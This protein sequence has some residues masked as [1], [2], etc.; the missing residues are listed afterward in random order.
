MSEV[1]SILKRVVKATHL[2]LKVAIEKLEDNASREE[3]LAYL[4][5]NNAVSF[6]IPAA[7]HTSMDNIGQFLELD[8]SAI[9]LEAF[10]EIVDDILI[11]SNIIDDS[12]HLLSSDTPEEAIE[13]T[14]D[15]FFQLCIFI[16]LQKNSYRSAQ[17]TANIVKVIMML[18]DLPV[19]HGATG[20]LGIIGSSLKFLKRLIL[21]V[22][23]N[24][25]DWSKGAREEW[26]KM[27]D[28]DWNNTW[29]TLTDDDRKKLS[30]Q[31]IKLFSDGIYFLMV[32]PLYFSEA[33]SNKVRATYGFDPPGE[34]L[35][36]IGDQISERVL[37]LSLSDKIKDT[38]DLETEITYFI[39]L[40]LRSSLDSGGVGLELALAGEGKLEY[41]IGAGYKLSVTLD[42]LPGVDA[43]LEF[44]IQKEGLGSNWNLGDSKGTRLNFGKAMFTSTASVA[45]REIDSKLS[46]QDCSF[47]LARNGSD[48]FLQSLIPEKGLQAGFE[49]GFGLNFKKGFYVDGGSGI[50]VFI[51]LHLELGPVTMDALY[52]KASGIPDGEGFQL[53]TSVGF[54]ADI[55]GITATV[56]QIGLL[57][58]F[59]TA[60]E[61]KNFHFADYSIALK[62]PTQI[63]LSIDTGGLT[64]GGFISFNPDKGEYIG[65]IELSYKKVFSIKA[66]AIITT[67]LP[68]GKPGYSLLLLISAEFEPIQLG[69]GFTWNGI[70]GILGVH[71][72]AKIDFLRAGLKTNTLKSILFPENIVANIARIV[73]DLNQAFPQ[74]QGHYLICPV[75]KFGWG[76]PTLITIE[77]GILIEIPFERLVIF[78]VIRAILPDQ[79]KPVL[80]LQVNFLGV[81]DFEN[82]LI[83]FDASLYD[84]S[85]LTLTLSGDFGLRIGWGDNPMFILSAGGFHPA[86]NKEE[87]NGELPNMQRITVSLLSGDNPRATLQCYFAI[88]SNTVQFGAKAELYASSSGFNVY[89]YLAFDV[90]IR[91]LGDFEAGFA[92]GLALRRNTTVLMGI[93]VEGVLA[94]TEPWDL[95]GKGSISFFFFSISVPF[96]ARWGGVRELV[97]VLIEDIKALLTEEIEKDTNWVSAIPVNNNLHVS[98]RK[99]ATAGPKVL[100]HPFGVL[101]FRQTLVPLEIDIDKFGNKLP[102][103]AKNF[104]IKINGTGLSTEPVKDQFA[105]GN[106]LLMEDAEKLSRPS[107]EQMTS[108]FSITGSAS[109]DAPQL[110]NKSVD[111]EFSYLGRKK[112]DLPMKNR[113]DFRKAMFKSSTRMSAVAGSPLSYLNSRVSANAPEKVTVS[114]QQYAIAGISDLK[115]YIGDEVKAGSYSEVYQQYR[116]IIRQRPELSE[117]LQ[118]VGTHEVNM[119]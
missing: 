83:S 119:N 112:K 115:L 110:I 13:E 78:G 64:G 63:G 98:V 1:K 76:T 66:I 27:S 65:A 77:V 96:H 116:N 20:T 105:P 82:K 102:K 15:L 38:A 29:Q 92:A 81:I 91:S 44:R 16:S 28:E 117:E 33:L 17:I 30:N 93:H 57:H 22:G 61:K 70:G 48:S 3:V 47:V 52:L 43:K 6:S 59:D 71:R 68:D 10:A 36:T 89:G 50:S 72:Q 88:T 58:S 25:K 106:F 31:Q 108:G 39:S 49:L 114:E 8:D 7:A 99:S 101:T 41:D 46:F 24:L 79:N 26:E 42:G 23:Q 45:D 85:F 40:A 12:I 14:I 2:I 103:D 84:S 73:S 69:M 97:E 55:L 11:V 18:S 34:S 118:V 21:S 53:E 86:F 90:L 113:Y 67:K 56:Q 60:A 104:K 87:L 62:P 74:Q 19:A 80:K 107:F 9:T 54:T 75:L 4:G 111:Y 32:V 35:E 100:I 95:K 37:T 109:L 94:G 51:P 5:Y